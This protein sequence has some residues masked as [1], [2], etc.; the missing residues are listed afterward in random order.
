MSPLLLSTIISA[1]NV[2]T[3]VLASGDADMVALGR[4]LIREPRLPL[5]W[6]DGRQR[7]ADCRSCNRC[8]LYKDRPL[9]CE[10]LMLEQE[11]EEAGVMGAG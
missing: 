8:A 5:D 6:L 2:R 11:K 4:P 9:R 10:S 3:D 1:R 7:A